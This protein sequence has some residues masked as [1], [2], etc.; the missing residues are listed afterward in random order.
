MKRSVVV[1]VGVALLACAAPAAAK[2]DYGKTTLNILPP[3][4]TGS[5]PPDKNGTDQLPLYD[6]LTPL[7]DRIRA[8]DLTTYFKSAR[9]F[10]PR[11]GSIERPKAGVQIRRD[12]WGVPHIRGR[13]R[14]DVFFGAGWETGRDRSLFVETLRYPSRLAVVDAPGLKALDLATSLRSFTPSAQTERFLRRETR[15]LRR[16]G[17]RGRRILRDVDA[18]VAGINAY[19]RKTG[20]KAKPWTRTDVIA[21]VGLLG[22]VFGAG[23]GDEVR[24]SQFLA[25]LRQR[26]GSSGDRV[27]RDLREAEDPAAPVTTTKRFPY[28]LNPRGKAPGSRVV[29][30]GSMSASAAHAAAVAQSGQRDM[31]NAILIGRKR[32]ASGHPLAVMGPQL[33]YYYPQ[34]FLEYDLHGGGIDVRGSG[35]PG[36]PYVMIGRTRD[37]AWSAT[38][39][40][41]DNTDEFVEKL[42]NPNGSAPTR[43]STHYV[44]KGRCRSMK[45]FNA[46]VLDG[47]TPVVF[48]E[49]VHGPVTGTVTI[50]GKPYAVARK[51]ATRGLEALNAFIGADL[52]SGAV[53]NARDFARVA[54]ELNF[55]FNLFYVDH[56]S[57]AFYTAGRL[58]IRARGT[59]P[60]LPTLGT[61]K[62][63]WR[64]FLSRRRHPQALDPRGG[65][66][67]ILNWNGKTAPGFNAADSQ[68]DYGSVDRVELFRGFKK[69][70]RLVDVV[71]VMNRAATQDLR[72][73]EVW[74]VIAR[75][76]QGGPA[77]DARTQQAAK[78][79]SS[80]RAHGSSR[81]DRNLDGRID[82]PGAAILDAAWAPMARA[83]LTPVLGDLAAANG[84][85]VQ[86]Q[87]VD[88]SP[89]DGNGSAYDDGW[90]GYVD[91]DLR[92][93]LGDHVRG[94][95]SRGY[96]GNGSLSACRA[97]LW[98]ALKGAVDGLAAS[99]GQD[100][101]GWASDS[102][103]ERIEFQPG[104]LG[105]RTMR[106]TNRPTF[107][108][109]MEFSGH[110]KI[111]AKHRKRRK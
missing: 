71:N 57:I 73:R 58:P 77:P 10:A 43:Q 75:V 61:G 104:L 63:E 48:R 46:G 6:G 109:L 108:Q 59:N 29:D 93:L 79:I 65:R 39:S 42:C 74:P 31:S 5:L 82:D 92:T 107:Q 111:R 41:S 84:P 56:R 49:T 18:Y 86:L 91:K 52:D 2:L 36:T 38:S 37:Y 85:L 78:L 87:Q 98:A 47:K 15:L 32:S 83:V 30:P 11:G 70:N 45:R 35:L 27:W 101:Q 50:H 80:W 81:L 64:G 54:N 3:G 51:R 22:Q 19:Y 100:P 88:D 103:A 24:S 110:R 66:G 90:Y 17:R 68:Q 13:T 97:S 105:S 94:R 25:Q 89:N 1:L 8:G 62:Y 76:L 53:R 16:K 34:L 55:T 23:G 67:L 7:F 72:V 12:S 102:S 33:G 40:G 95:F 20:N 96:C 4:Q 26:M 99:Q 44:F 9:F 106:W 21:I 14:S 60:S 28:Q 69:R